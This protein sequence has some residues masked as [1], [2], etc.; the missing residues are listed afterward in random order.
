ML[1][2]LCF[3]NYVYYFMLLCSLIY[4]YYFMLTFKTKTGS[5]LNLEPAF[6]IAALY[7][8]IYSGS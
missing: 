3:C 4:V 1:I 8:W 6:A 7:E 2:I 5:K